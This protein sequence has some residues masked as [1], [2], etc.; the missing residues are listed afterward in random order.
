M[1]EFTWGLITKT[2]GLKL[3]LQYLHDLGEEA[4]GNGRERRMYGSLV[5]SGTLPLEGRRSRTSLSPQGHA[6]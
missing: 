6:Y 2:I 1:L 3:F 5:P 4:N